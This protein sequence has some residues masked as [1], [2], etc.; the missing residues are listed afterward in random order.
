MSPPVAALQ[1]ISRLMPLAQVHAV[2]DALVAPVPAREIPLKAAAGRILAMDVTAAAPAPA[3]S[4]ATR[5]GWAVRSDQVADAG[6]YSPV[7]LVPAAK[8]V[9]AGD[10][11]PV[12]T[13]AVLPPDGLIFT[14]GTPE[15]I[16]AVSPGEG[17]LPAGANF[18]S[19][20]PLRRAGEALRATAL[21]ALHA[22]GIERV[23]IRDPRVHVI[24]TDPAIDQARDIVAPLIATAVGAAGG[25][26]EIAR[27]CQ[28]RDAL[29]RALGDEEV[30]AIITIGGTGAGRN[31]RTIRELAR[32]GHVHI[33]GIG[34]QPGETAGLGTVGS[35]PALLLPGR[36]DAALAAWLLVGRKLL[37]RLTGSSGGEPLG[38]VVLLRR[39]GDGLEPISGPHIPLRALAQAEGWVLVPPESEGYQAGAPVDLRPLP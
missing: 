15:S 37:D 14:G 18:A 23:A 32:A 13:D 39:A 17:A 29:D 8:W 3:A 12:G 30:D 1:R 33:N 24:S 34:I 38:S 7:P 35:R 11:L 31:D 5:D 4:V 16:A 26:A 20:D 25:R 28:D 6:P 19:G 36:L 9:D 10:P 22:A 27:V 21:A 2:L